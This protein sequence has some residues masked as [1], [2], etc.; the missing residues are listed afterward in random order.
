MGDSGLIFVTGQQSRV[1][2]YYIIP[3]VGYIEKLFFNHP[4]CL[5]CLCFQ[6]GPARRWCSF[7]DGLTEELQEEKSTTVYEDYTFVTKK[8]LEELGLLHI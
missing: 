5:L 8:E 6:L 4:H 7:L 1:M 2:T 3:Q